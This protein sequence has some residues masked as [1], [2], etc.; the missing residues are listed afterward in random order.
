M[1]ISRTLIGPGQANRQIVARIP[2]QDERAQDTLR[3]EARQLPR[4]ECGI[5][6]V[7]VNRQ[8]SAFESWSERVPQRFTAG[9]HTRVAAVILFMHSTIPTANG[10]AWLPFVR[11]I[12]NP[13]ARR[14]LPSWITATVDAICAETRRLTGRSD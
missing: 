6:M 4:N 11:L 9:Q 3:I 10:L 12:A 13:H 1:A 8:P 14:P 5:V 7:N 2:F